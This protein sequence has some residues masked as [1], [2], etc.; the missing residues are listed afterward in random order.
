MDN[1]TRSLLVV[2]GVLVVVALVFLTLMGGMMGPGFAEWGPAAPGM[3]QDH[4]WMW[5]LGM[6]LG[7]LAMLIF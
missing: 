4:W 1:T 5:G 6:G 7:G 3:M 2:L